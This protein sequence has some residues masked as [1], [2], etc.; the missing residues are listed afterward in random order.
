[1]SERIICIFVFQDD[2]HGLISS[3]DVRGTNCRRKA[4]DEYS[5]KKFCAAYVRTFY[6]DG[7]IVV[8]DAMVHLAHTK[9][10]V[11]DSEL[12]I[13]LNWPDRDV[14]VS[15]DRLMRC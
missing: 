1:M 11:K 3:H 7:E 10:R 14:R 9:E 8:F 13:H 2:K 6:S 4:Y 12:G 15:L 5:F